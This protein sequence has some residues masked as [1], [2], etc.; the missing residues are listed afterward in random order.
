[1]LMLQFLPLINSGIRTD[2]SIIG[3]AL[4]DAEDLTVSNGDEAGKG[5]SACSG[6]TQLDFSRMS[7]NLGIT[8]SLLTWWPLEAAVVRKKAVLVLDAVRPIPVPS[9]AA[10]KYRQIPPDVAHRRKRS[11][12]L[13]HAGF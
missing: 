7:A 3:S 12:P 11:L 9:G 8:N 4:A 13:Y 2:Q 6:K 5:L 10:E 1:M